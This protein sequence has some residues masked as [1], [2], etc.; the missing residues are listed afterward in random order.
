MKKLLQTTV[1]LLLLLSISFAGFSQYNVKGMVTDATKNEPLSNVSVQIKGTRSGTMTG[2]DGTF[3]LTIPDNKSVALVISQ[4]GFVSQS[5]S[6][7]PNNTAIKVALKI[8]GQGIQRHRQ[9]LRVPRQGSCRKEIC[10]SE[11]TCRVRPGW[12]Q[13]S[14]SRDAD[15]SQSAGPREE[16]GRPSSQHTHE[17]DPEHRFQSGNQ[18]R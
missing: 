16:S 8:D 6:V 7:S 5:V 11:R 3:I 9:R 13:V 17:S 10:S 1:P 14:A 18:A 12:L 4:V 15:S 2:T